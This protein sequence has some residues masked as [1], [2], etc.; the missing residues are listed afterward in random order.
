M[1]HCLLCPS[2]AVADALCVPCGARLWAA[3]TI[4][5]RSRETRPEGIKLGDWMALREQAME[6]FWPSSDSAPNFS[7]A[8]GF[9]TRLEAAKAARLR[10]EGACPECERTTPRDPHKTNCSK[11]VI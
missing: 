6:S 4:A 5:L 9:I 2:P 7:A 10:K 3:L 1:T 8:S 11:G